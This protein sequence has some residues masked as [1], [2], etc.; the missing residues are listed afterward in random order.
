MSVG[1]PPGTSPELEGELEMLTVAE[2][3]EYG[4]K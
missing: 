1:I 4:W 2:G 3:E